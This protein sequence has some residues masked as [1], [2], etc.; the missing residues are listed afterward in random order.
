MKKYVKG[1]AVKYINTPWQET[2]LELEGW[3]EEKPKKKG[4]QDEQ[5]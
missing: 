2:V 4:K 5:E 3:T 1:D